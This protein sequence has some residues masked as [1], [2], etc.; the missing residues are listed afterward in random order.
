MLGKV[1]VSNEKDM[2]GFE[3]QEAYEHTTL[4][5]KRPTVI[6]AR[7]RFDKGESCSGYIWEVFPSVTW[8][9]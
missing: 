6:T 8:P 2:P 4:L 3:T 1:L 9:H 7:C 5:P